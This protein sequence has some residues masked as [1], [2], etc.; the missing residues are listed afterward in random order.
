[1]LLLILSATTELFTWWEVFLHARQLHLSSSLSVKQ[2]LREALAFACEIIPFGT[3]I[4]PLLEEHKIVI[5]GGNVAIRDRVM[6]EEK[7]RLVPVK[8]H[9]HFESVVKLLFEDVSNLVV[10]WQLS[11]TGSHGTGAGETVATTR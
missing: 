1:V 2:R 6:V 4:W 9:S 5:R 3:V 11:P 8:S 10:R 7:S